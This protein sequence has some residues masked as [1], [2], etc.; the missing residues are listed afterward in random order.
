MDQ[1]EVYEAVKDIAGNV[2]QEAEEPARHVRRV[3]YQSSSEMRFC[4][5]EFRVNF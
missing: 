2:Q 5:E 1:N 3:L 4:N